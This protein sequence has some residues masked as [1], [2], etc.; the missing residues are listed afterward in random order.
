MSLSNRD[1]VGRALDLL[2]DGLKPFVVREMEST[3]GPRWRY[4]AVNS[5]RDHHF[6]EDGQDL[7]LDIQ[8]L[9]LIMWDQWNQVFKKTL[10]HTERNYVS[11]LREARNKW[12]H[13]QPFST[14]AAYRILD[15]IQLLLAAISATEQADEVE[16]QKMELLRLSFDEQARNITRRNTGAL[17]G[18]QLP[19]GLLPWREVITPHPDVASGNYPVAEFAAD[20]SQVYRG[21]ATSEYADANAFF[22][23]TYLTSGLRQLLLGAL[24]RLSGQGGDP[25][26]ELQTSF[27]GGKTHS[28]LALYHLFSGTSAPDLV[29]IE[30]LLHEVDVQQA[31]VAQRAIL[32][33]HALSPA[34]AERKPDGCEVHTIWG[35]MAWQLLGKDGYAMVA[36]DDRL[37]VSPGSEVLRQLFLAASPAL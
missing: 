23:R 31:P 8:A 33:G 5:L 4:E 20:L 2:N 19:R 18:G 6:T 22:R 9:L 32:V 24:R 3:Y 30:P 17:V 11:E 28:L 14:Q 36:E 7:R 15:S 10:G 29:G 27:G 12:A 1:R 26:V 21:I 25:I 37:G 13:Q 16:R 34:K 35:E